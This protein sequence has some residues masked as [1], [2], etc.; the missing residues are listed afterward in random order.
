M[1]KKQQL[2]DDDSKSLE[3][4]KQL[5]EKTADVTFLVGENEDRHRANKCMLAMH[6]A[7]WEAAFYGDFP[8]ER[9]IRIE[10][11]GSET[12]D[13]LLL[14][15][16]GHKVEVTR[17][18]VDDLLLAASKYM[19]K[20]LVKRCE[21]FIIGVVI[22]RENCFDRLVAHQNMETP[23][24]F[25]ECVNLIVFS[26]LAYLDP[27]N[28]ARLTGH[29]LKHIVTRPGINCN[30]S[31][32]EA[33]VL[34]W[35]NQQPGVTRKYREM[36]ETAYELLASKVGIHKHDLL[37][38]KP[39]Q[40]RANWLGDIQWEVFMFQDLFVLVDPIVLYGIAIY[41]GLRSEALEQESVQVWIGECEVPYDHS[42]DEMEQ[43][44]DFFDT[45]FPAELPKV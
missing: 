14:H 13:S 44:T 39:Y 45:D 29:A 20:K 3:E 1:A 35:L 4:L 17:Q 33:I 24:I 30:A 31:D 34:A 43:L 12:F 27:V 40:L 2:R 36:T 41:T 16:Y 5:M 10:D 6:S 25:E 18:N 19:V 15:I 21:T 28:C 11:I 38:K 22:D 26:P 7:V 8:V 37:H 32:L 23:A 9:E 42:F